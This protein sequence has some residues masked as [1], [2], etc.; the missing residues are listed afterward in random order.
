MDIAFIIPAAI[1]LIILL[2]GYIYESRKST[3]LKAK[4]D[5]AASLL[6]EAY[7]ITDTEPETRPL[8][9]KIIKEG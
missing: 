7:K 8:V 5:A 2:I 9:Y 1:I 3:S 6:N 4:L